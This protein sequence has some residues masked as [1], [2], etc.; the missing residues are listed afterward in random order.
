MAMDETSCRSRTQL[1]TSEERTP[2][3]TQSAEGHCRKCDQRDPGR[4]R[5]EPPQT[6]RS[7]LAHFS[8][9]PDERMERA[10]HL[11][12]PASP[13]YSI[14]MCLRITFSGSDRKSVV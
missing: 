13:Q 11:A 10:A 8:V 4:R 12:R 14:P 7:F 5:D 3:G 1:R 9:L 2:L 6:P